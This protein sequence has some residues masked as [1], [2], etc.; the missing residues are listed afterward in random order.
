M[1]SQ[2]AFKDQSASQLKL[3]LT[4]G[5]A[6]VAALQILQMGKVRFGNVQIE[7]GILGASHYV[8]WWTEGGAFTEVL[9]CVSAWPNQT[10]LASQHLSSLKTTSEFEPVPS[11]KYYFHHWQSDWEKGQ[12]NVDSIKTQ[13][14]KMASTDGLGLH[15]SFPGYNGAE[16]LLLIENSKKGIFAQSLHAYPNEGKLIFSKSYILKQKI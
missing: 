3:H 16:T 10:Y 14:Q 12:E 9:A 15:F 8:K 5:I 2:L 11:W 1:T 4:K 7:A 13:L 6:D